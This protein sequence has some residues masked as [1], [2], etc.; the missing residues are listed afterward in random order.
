MCKRASD[1]FEIRRI[2]DTYA[3]ILLDYIGIKVVVDN[4]EKAPQEKSVLLCNHR[5]VI[6]PLVIDLAVESTPLYGLWIAKKELYNSFFFGVFVRNAGTILL[7]R[8]SSQMGGFFKEVKEEVK[9]GCSICIFP[10][11]TR[12]KTDKN[13]T[14]FKEGAK[15]IAVKNRLPIIPIYIKTN[16][17]EA[18]KTALKTKGKPQEVHVQFGDPI[19]PKD[20]SMSLE[21][22]YRK[23]FDI[24]D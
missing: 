11:G 22:N 12:N 7:D 10:E 18:L 23:Q 6:D 17:N 21:E 8:E 2:R 3:H 5:S 1:N 19:D 14:E 20:K 24:I 9:N 16:A 4:P 13:L 15:I